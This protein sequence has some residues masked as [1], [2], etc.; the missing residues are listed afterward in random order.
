MKDE[1]KSTLGFYNFKF[2][3]LLH[4]FSIQE[5]DKSFDIE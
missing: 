3:D 4:Q 1:L 2:N 5:Q